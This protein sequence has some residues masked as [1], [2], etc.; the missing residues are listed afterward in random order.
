M[1][2][3][4]SKALAIGH[5]IIDYDH[6]MLV[7]IANDLD[8]AVQSGAG[9]EAV[10]Q[11]LERLIQYV[12][13]HFKREEELFL[14]SGYPFKAKHQQNHRDIE[15][16]VRGFQAA[17]A[18][19]PASVDMD[20]LLNFFREWLFKHIGKLDRGYAEYVLEAEKSSGHLNQRKGFV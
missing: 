10:G 8:Y 9:N 6:Q 17:F 13:S 5:P 3:Q 16:L 12:E 14:A 2:L 11:S 4:W 18:A 19:D 20:K 15:K 7:N 1:L